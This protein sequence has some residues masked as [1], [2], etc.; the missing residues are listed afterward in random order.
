MCTQNA[1]RGVFVLESR[2]RAFKRSI[3]TVYSLIKNMGHNSHGFSPY[4]KTKKTKKTAKRL[5][6]KKAMH[7]ERESKKKKR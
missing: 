6:T 3:I 7:A 5:A 2:L 4:K 1:L